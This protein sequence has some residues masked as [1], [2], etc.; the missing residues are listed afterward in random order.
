MPRPR[1]TVGLVLAGVVLASGCATADG[2]GNGE[3][4][5]PSTSVAAG[6]RS[7]FETS[8][9][10]SGSREVAS[11]SSTGEVRMPPRSNSVV[12]EAGSDPQSVVDVEVGEVIS[13]YAGEV[14]DEGTLLTLDEPI[15]FDFDSAE[16]RRSAAGALQEIAAVLEHYEDAPVTIRG[17]TDG[18]GTD[19]YNDQL[20]QDRA[21][22]VMEALRGY[23]VAEAR[24][25]AEGRGSREPVADETRGD[26]SD[27]PEAR[28]SNRRVE[29]LIEGV[30][31]PQ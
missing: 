9:G 27:D 2:D 3:T 13:S 25:S 31:P 18:R 22:A 5:S 29:I 11:T 17:H 7:A 8:P 12:R 19:A 14:V 28:A 30:E 4:S 26:G 15:L 21:D 6:D 1:R 23:G 10:P 16:L 24:M 20:S